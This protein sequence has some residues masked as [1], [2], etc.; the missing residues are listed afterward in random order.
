MRPSQLFFRWQMAKTHDATPRPAKLALRWALQTETRNP[1]K[2][3]PCLDKSLIC[4]LDPR[5]VFVQRPSCLHNLSIRSSRLGMRPPA[6]FFLPRWT[7]AWCYCYA[8]A[9]LVLP[10]SPI[11]GCSRDRVIYLSLYGSRLSG[12]LMEEAERRR[13]QDDVRDNLCG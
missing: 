9:V 3:S 4:L 13:P 5:P 1:C 7:F 8:S 10:P 11:R 12:P 6:C 2:I